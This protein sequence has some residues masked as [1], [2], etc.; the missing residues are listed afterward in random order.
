MKT[1]TI[2]Q[3]ILVLA[4]LACSVGCTSNST[5]TS[6]DLSEENLQELSLVERF[7]FEDLDGNK[8]NWEDTNGKLVF[9]NFWAT[10][11]KPCIREMPSISE[12]NIQLKNEGVMFIV[13]SDEDVQKIQK[14]ESKHHYSFSLV[15]TNTSVFDL[16]IQALPSTLIINENGEIVFNEIGARDWSSDKSIAL[17]KSFSVNNKD[18]TSL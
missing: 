12:A 13:A 3:G 5:E 9:V 16:D 11:C 2:I 1:K 10:W 15:H 4:T 6:K 18:E 14:F 8:I 17:I 7:D